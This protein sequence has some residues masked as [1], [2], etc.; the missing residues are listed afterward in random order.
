MRAVAGACAAAWLAASVA[1]AADLAALERA[2]AADPENL[3]VAAEYRQ[4]VLRG[5]DVDRSIRFLEQLARRGRGPNIQISLALACVD[6]VPT[7]GEMRR[8]YLGRDAINALTKAIERQP[9]VLAYYTRGLINLYYNRLIF[10]RVPR[11]IADLE[12]ARSMV[13]VDTPG[14][15]VRRVYAAL[16]DGHFKLGETAAAHEVWAAGLARFPAD[17]DLKARLSKQGRDLYWV[18]TDALDPGRRVDTSLVGLL[19]AP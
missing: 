4:E 15:L 16:G 2:V 9:S 12:Q 6:K 14:A 17:A 10:H 11:G 7:A 8:L 18:V 1:A 3:R 13:T 19:P 5:G